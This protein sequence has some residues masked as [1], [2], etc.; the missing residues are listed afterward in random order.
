MSPEEKRA[1]RRAAMPITTAFVTR[2]AEFEP[3][4]IYAQENGIMVGKMPIDESAFTV[5]LGYGLATGVPTK[6]KR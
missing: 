5:P 2:Y 6:A 4:V 3:T 1:A